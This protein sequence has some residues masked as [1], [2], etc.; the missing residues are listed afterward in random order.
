MRVQTTPCANSRRTP[1]PLTLQ[2]NTA[3]FPVVL[4]ANTPLGFKLD[5]HL[6][7]VIQSDLSVNL[8]AANGVTISKLPPPNV[9]GGPISLLGHLTGTVE[10]VGT[11]QF[12]VQTGEGRTFNIGVNSSTTYS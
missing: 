1:R 3:P 12:T 2:F 10:S 11:N 7:T 9:S 4:A 6:N 8:A 5:I